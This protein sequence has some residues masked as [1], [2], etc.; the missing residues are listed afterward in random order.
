MPRE[1]EVIRLNPPSPSLSPC[2]HILKKKRTTGSSLSLVSPARS[3][4]F[5]R[6]TLSVYWGFLYFL[7][8]QIMPIP[9]YR[10]IFNRIYF[11]D[12]EIVGQM[13]G[14]MGFRLDD[15]DGGWVCLERKQRSKWLTLD[16]RIEYK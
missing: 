4:H 13:Q 10:A 6:V 16:H 3:F 14:G 15:I 5:K 1:V 2:S 8:M 9:P 12:T 11:G 7:T